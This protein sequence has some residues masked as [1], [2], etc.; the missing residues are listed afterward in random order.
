MYYPPHSVHSPNSLHALLVLQHLPGLGSGRY[1]RLMEHFSDASTVLQQAA[2]TLHLF[3][4][5]EARSMLAD[6]Q[7]HGDISTLGRTVAQNLDWL[8][9]QPDIQLLTIDHPHYPELLRQIA[10]PPALLY[11]HGDVSCL[12]LPQIAV[13]GSRNP[14]SG[15]ADNAYQFSRHL[16]A[17]G[18]AITSGLALG[19]DGAAHRGALAAKGKTIAVFGTGIDTLYPARH[20]ALAQEIVAEGGALV[21]EFP[22]GTRSHAGNFP[23]RNRLI[24][25]LSCGTLVVEAAMQS[26]SL[27]TARL[28]LQQNREVFAIPGSIHNPL[29]RGC[30]SLIKEGATLVETG[31]DIV[32]Q[33]GGML[34]FKREELVD[35]V[36]EQTKNTFSPEEKAL[37]TAIGFDPT[38]FDTVV[39]RCGMAVGKVAAQLMGLELKGAVNAT[40]AGYVRVN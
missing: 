28:A 39:E 33:L 2:H 23:Q 37:L 20:R 27:I 34:A 35:S 31:A 30:H 1:W 40:D 17:H 32:E 25:G 5:E 3:L 26:G 16:A 6:Y 7:Q 13:V 21:S 29:A 24:S 38:P 9:Q 36:T 19:V 22:L 4:T 18:F 10:R 8:E 12:S 14:S 11:V 15:G